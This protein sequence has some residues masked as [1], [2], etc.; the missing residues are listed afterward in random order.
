MNYDLVDLQQLKISP[1]DYD[2]ANKNDDHLSVIQSMIHAKSVVFATPVYW[3][4]MSSQMKIFFDRLSDLLTIRNDL[5]PKLKGRRCFL[6]ATGTDANLPEGFETPFR[7]TCDYLDMV[8][9]RSLYFCRG[10]PVTK[11]SI[12]SF[13]ADLVGGPLEP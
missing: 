1:F 4:A 5:L 10:S 12:Q 2:H 8:Y 13:R 7:R 9:C 6:A 11:K 3:Y